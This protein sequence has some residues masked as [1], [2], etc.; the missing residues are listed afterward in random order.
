M[1]RLS[2]LVLVGVLIVIL[3]LLVVGSLLTDKGVREG[4]VDSSN[5]VL[6]YNPTNERINLETIDLNKFYKSLPV[7]LEHDYTG[8]KIH[9]GVVNHHLLADQL[10]AEFFATV[11]TSEPDLV[12]LVGPNHTGEGLETIHT[13][14]WDYST[15]FG[16]LP[17]NR[18]LISYL[19]KEEQVG[20]NYHL[21]EIEHSINALIPYIKYYLPDVEL[22]PLIM[23]SA[24]EI[25]RVSGLAERLVEETKER[26]VLVLASIDFS[27]YLPLALADE[28]DLVTKELML[29]RDYN[30]LARLND[31]Y[32]DSPASGVFL[33]RMV[34]LLGSKDQLLINQS[35]SA[36]I[37]PSD[38][39]NTTSYM[40]IIYF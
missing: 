39:H 24:V 5:E 13:S 14:V 34:D 28:R 27:H 20:Y 35:N 21:A 18:D 38:F 15:P 19:I 9:G 12:I 40:T 3:G 30:S 8:K 36:R 32:L 6:T 16:E 31:D 25:S 4:T 23:S 33:L 37:H 7:S 11:A 26:N 1:K 17:I 29:N 22:V 10:I 2:I